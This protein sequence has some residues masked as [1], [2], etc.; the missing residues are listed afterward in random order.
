MKALIT[1]AAA[2]L[3]LTACSTQRRAAAPAATE[4]TAPATPAA[5]F[6]AMTGTYG[7]WHDVQM[8]VRATLRSPFSLSASG[9]MTMV[10]DSLIHISMRVLGM[11]VAVMQVTQDSV[12]VV[13][14]FHHYLIAESTRRLTAGTGLTMADLQ[15]A[16]LGRA[17][18]P[19]MGAATASM[20]GELV[21]EGAGDG[22][23]ISPSKAPQGYTWQ[24]NAATLDDG[25]VALTDLSVS[26]EGHEPATATYTP[27]ARLSA[28]G[29][30]ATAIDL[31][32]R[33]AGRTVDARLTYSPDEA[34]WNTGAA[35]A[36][37]SLRGYTRVSTAQLL[38]GGFM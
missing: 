8:P 27:A 24:M 1:I 17:F 22:L 12:Y 36:L 9:R 4:Q 15:S 37:P 6:A 38:K 26:V 25:R 29:A 34:R 35:P 23:T 20:G 10:H 28:A 14:K 2:A 3:L 32:A 5:R 30:V 18:V 19:G 33:V 31:Q 7:M 11:E 21:L 16:L 13:D